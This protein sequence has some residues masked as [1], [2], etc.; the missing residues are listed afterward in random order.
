ML[1]FYSYQKYVS[2]QDNDDSDEEEC[3]E[4][5]YEEGMVWGQTDEYKEPR[6]EEGD[7]EEDYQ[8]TSVEQQYDK[9][10]SNVVALR[11]P[12]LPIFDTGATSHKAPHDYGVF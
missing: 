11:G 9:K 2:F 12:N 10:L 7:K 5:K 3:D 4:G 6:L 1:G 8:L